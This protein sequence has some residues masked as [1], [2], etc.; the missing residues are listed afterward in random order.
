MLGLTAMGTV[1]IILEPPY[2]AATALPLV[3]EGT[4]ITY[5]ISDGLPSNT[6]WG[7]VAVD[8]AGRVWA[9]FE[10][11]GWI[12]PLPTNTLI[13]RL[14]GAN[15]INYQLPGCRVWPLVA[16]SQ[17]YAGSYCPGPPADAGGGLSWFSDEGWVNF[18]PADSMVGT[19]ISAIT[20]EGND[21]VWVAAG[22]S[23]VEHNFVNMLDHKGTATKSDDE[24]TIYDL[25]PRSVFAVAIDP[26]GNRWFGTSSGV[27]VLS[28][29]DSTWITY[30]SDLANYVTDIAFDASGNA[31]FASGQKVTRFDGHTW[32]HYNSREEAIQANYTAIMTS[33]NRNRVNPVYWPG[34]WA[35]EPDAGVWVM[36]ATP[37][38]YAAG[39]GFY[40]GESWTIYTTQ[41]SG[42]GNDTRLFGIAIDQQNSVWVGTGDT[43]AGGDGGLNKFTP[44]PNFSVS[45]PLFTLFIRPDGIATGD[46]LISHLRGWIPT[47][48]LSAGGLPPDT[49]IEFSS[50]PL[51]PTAHSLFSITTMPVAPLGTY[52]LSITAASAEVT[53]T[54]AI[55][56]LVVPYVYKYYW[57]VLL[58]PPHVYQYYLPV[59]FQSA[60]SAK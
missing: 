22:Y 36:R 24:W 5:T 1:L 35:I 42:L 8:N 2:S 48:T 51:T 54:I 12:Y 32:T 40:D 27:L 20:P 57:P 37:S 33:L 25:S 49:Y 44:P 31:W 53:R 29:D 60:R 3:N 11:G 9:G 46:I 41:N 23:L 14:D 43:Y 34:L 39:I 17:V 58:V 10:K 26:S 52:P 19:Y 6:V 13:S 4:W 28:S 21:R 50:N 59:V 30:T 56:L 55:T 7:G 47:T 15:W 16:E 45:V 38:G 18:T